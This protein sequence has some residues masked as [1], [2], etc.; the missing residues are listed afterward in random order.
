MIRLLVIRPEPGASETVAA[1]RA[2]GLAAEAVPLFAV[3]PVAWQAPDPSQFD[4]LL[5]GSAN[6]PR[7]AG[8]HLASLRRLP[9][10]AVGEATRQACRDA[11]L[12]VALAGEGGLQSVLGKLDPAHRRLLRLAGRERVPLA[13]PQGVSVSEQ[14]VYASEPR[15]MPPELATRL[16]DGAVVLLHSAEAARHFAAECD[17]LSVPRGGIALVVLGTR[18]AQAAGGGWWTVS[19]ADRPSD[20]ALLAKACALCQDHPQAGQ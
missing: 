1:A 7:H 14:V 20:T 13:L 3:S 2:M 4:A 9:V 19:V 17:R 5:I 18:V 8:P 16:A 11:G 15:A 6:A 10:Y 12:T